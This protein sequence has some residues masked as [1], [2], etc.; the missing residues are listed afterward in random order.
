MFLRDGPSVGK[1]HILLYRRKDPGPPGSL[2]ICLLLWTGGQRE[3][4]PGALGVVIWLFWE[5]LPR[6][7]HRDTRLSL[8]AL[9]A[10]EI[11][12]GKMI[13]NTWAH[14]SYLDGRKC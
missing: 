7:G 5:H 3:V 14:F 2:T 4:P 10:G 1:E 12:T 8:T 11:S 9:A 6:V 13:N